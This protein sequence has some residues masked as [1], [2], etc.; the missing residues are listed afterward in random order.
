MRRGLLAIAVAV[1]LLAGCGDQGRAPIVPADAFDATV[2]SPVADNATGASETAIAISV[3]VPEHREGE[4]YPLIL[5]GHGW[6]GSRIDPTEARGEF[7]TSSFFSVVVDR[8]VAAFW[9]EGYAVVSFDE[10][11]FEDSGGAVRV[12][13]PEFETRDAIAILDWAERHLDLARDGSGDPVVGTIGGS[14]GGGFQLLLAA[15]D[16]RIDAIAP[17]VTWHDLTEALAPGGVIKKGFVFGL[18][19]SARIAGRVF[20]PELDR[21]CRSVAEDPATRFADEVDPAIV[22]FLAGHGLAA[23]EARHE[24]PSDPF[25]MR[26]VDALLVQGQRDFLFN[27][28]QA[29][30]NFRFLASLGGDVRLLTHQHGHILPGGLASQ[31][32]LGATSC[33][34]IDTI[35]AMH[36]WFDAKLRGRPEAI[37]ELPRVCLSLDDE[38]GVELGDVPR[39]DGS[40]V[41]EIP[42]GTEVGPESSN[43]PGGA[44]P[45]FVPLAEPLPGGDRVLAGIPVADLLVEP[46]EGGSEAVAFVGIGIQSPGEP[47]RLVDDQV[48]PLRAGRHERVELIG[49]ADALAAG[50][51]VGVLLYGR[52]DQY[53]NGMRTSFAANRYRI[54]G[55]VALPILP[56][57]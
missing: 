55:T 36:A 8:E 26:A 33:G 23:F 43:L 38:R 46:V 50:D 24:D 21:A 7:D 41:A 47:P 35:A 44:G 56:A 17:S 48:A 4:T 27:L 10:R 11:G 14:Y 49:V 40:V 2:R 13:D 37:A 29:V 39:A 34:R 16:P 5:H 3:Y 30:E 22:D 15:L 57:R 19:V 45:F 20:D 6:G 53:E 28:N 32:P 31:A 25:R 9:D 54:S 52:F 12:M 42:P 1:A 51:R 18:C